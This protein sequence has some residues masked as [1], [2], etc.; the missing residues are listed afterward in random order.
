MPTLQRIFLGRITG[1][2]MNLDTLPTYRMEH[3]NEHFQAVIKH[4]INLHDFK[5]QHDSG[6]FVNI[7]FYFE[8]DPR[9]DEVGYTGFGLNDFVC[10]SPTSERLITI[11]LLIGYALDVDMN[12][13]LT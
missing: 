4:I 8:D 7:D 1:L 13:A 10:G 3:L 5:L 6:K 12:D 11:I 9:R 2:I